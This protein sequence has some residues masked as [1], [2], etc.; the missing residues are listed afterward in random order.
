MGEDSWR[1]KV[2]PMGTDEVT[3]FLEEPVF[4]RVAT[5]D[6]HGWPYVVP[7]WHE[8]KDGRFWVVGR[9]RSKWAKN[10]A[11]DP[12]C[13]VTVDEYGMQRKVVAQCRAEVVEEP[14]V[15]GQWVEIARRMSVRYLG[16]HGPDYLE[17]TLEWSRWL[18]ALEPVQVWTWMGNDWAPSYKER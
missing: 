2:G 6:E 16:E 1:G 11:S 14:N 18:I 13:A 17:P 15:G 3:Q 8:W 10:L 9:K 5:L 12:R 7:M 4:A